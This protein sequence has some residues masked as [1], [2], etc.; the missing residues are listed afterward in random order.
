MCMCSATEYLLNFNYESCFVNLKYL[1]H[2]PQ[3]FCETAV[4]GFTE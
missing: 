3:F 2:A 4:I 1:Y